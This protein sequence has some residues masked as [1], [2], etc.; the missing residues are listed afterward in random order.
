VPLLFNFALRF[1]IRAKRLEPFFVIVR[2]HLEVVTGR[3]PK[4]R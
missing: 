4:W 3:S 1:G 2:E